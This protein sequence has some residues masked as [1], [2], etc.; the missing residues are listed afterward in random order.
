MKSIL[1][2]L[3]LIFLTAC[4]T[5]K[6]RP[7]ITTD[8]ND[9]RIKTLVGNWYSKKDPYADRPTKYI[10]T[11]QDSCIIWTI[12]KN[13]TII[14]ENLIS[15]TTAKCR[16]ILKNNKFYIQ[17]N[18]EKE[19]YA[20]NL[21]N[22]ISESELQVKFLGY[23][24]VFMPLLCD[25][26]SMAY[27]MNDNVFEYPTNDRAR[28]GANKDDLANYITKKIKFSENVKEE[29]SCNVLIKTNCNGEV[30]EAKIIGKTI[31]SKKTDFEK[32][33]IEVIE[34]MPKWNPATKRNLAKIEP[35]NGDNRFMFTYK[36]G[37]II[38][39]EG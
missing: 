23:K 7:K 4:K 3:L 14:I 6:H 11:V 29:T 5:S 30:V 39:R 2:I 37:K 1:T 9:P 38:V 32:S 24:N 22:A 10:K 27:P 26:E 8:K 25:Y 19:F 15:K 17:L 33:I 12:N 31:F 16:W 35:I 20:V 13:G 28:F 34:K 18:L 21:L 36:G